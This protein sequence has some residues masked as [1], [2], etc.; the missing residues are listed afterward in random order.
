MGNK[1][2]KDREEGRDRQ[3]EKVDMR[4]LKKKRKMKERSKLRE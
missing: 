4:N 2:Q 3:T 1:V